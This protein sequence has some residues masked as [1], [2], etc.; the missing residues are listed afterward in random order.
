MLPMRAG[1]QAQPFQLDRQT[2]ETENQRH[3]DEGIAVC[4][5]PLELS[6]FARFHAAGLLDREGQAPVEQCPCD[7]AH[8]AVAAEGEHE[9]R[10]LAFQEV[11][12]AFI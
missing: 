4:S 2:G 9:V 1:F 12:V 8:I 11:V 3:R 6:D 5:D 10:L 7:P